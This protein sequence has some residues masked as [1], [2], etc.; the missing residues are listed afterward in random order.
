MV[1]LVRQMMV[2]DDQ[3]KLTPT[4]LTESVQLRV[5]HAITPG[6]EYMNY[7]NGPS[8]HDQ[9]FFEFRIRRQDL[10]ARHSVGL[11]RCTQAKR[12]LPRSVRTA[13]TPS[14]PQHIRIRRGSY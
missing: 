11:A 8:S 9:D 10:F 6:T 13:Q 7:I 1:A 2:I 4:A 5:Y 3:G 14:S 12:S